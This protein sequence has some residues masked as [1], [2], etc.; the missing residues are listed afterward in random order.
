VD[1]AVFRGRLTRRGA[2]R[3]HRVA[4]TVADLTSVRAGVNHAPGVE[5]VDVALRLR[6]GAPLLSRTVAAVAG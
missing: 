1:D 5:E 3:V 6:M 2:V 4:W